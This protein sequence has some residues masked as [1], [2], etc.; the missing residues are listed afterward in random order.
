M[1]AKVLTVADDPR[2]VQRVVGALAGEPLV[3]EACRLGLP[4]TRRPC[5]D[6]IVLDLPPVPAGWPLVDDLRARSDV[7]LILLVADGADDERIEGLERG[8]DDCLGRS[9]SPVELRARVRLV[10]HR[11]HRAARAPLRV[12]N[13]WLDP[14]HQEARLHEAPLR[15]RRHEFAV[16]LALARQPGLVFSRGRLVELTHTA[17]G[18]P[19]RPDTIDVYASRL[20]RKLAGSGLTIRAV[21]GVGYK[22]DIVPPT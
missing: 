10:L 17:R 16:L 14:V 21:R 5:T 12:H 6:L 3:L 18:R 15:L 13:L 11:S 4:T 2:V 19:A 1:P 7:P 20:R 9:F 22:L 8:A